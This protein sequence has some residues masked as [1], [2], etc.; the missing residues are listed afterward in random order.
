[1]KNTLMAFSGGFLLC[2]CAVVAHG[3]KERQITIPTY[4]EKAEDYHALPEF[5]RKAYTTGL[6]DGFYGAAMFGPDGKGAEKLGACTKGMDTT[7]ITAIIS[8]YVADHPEG[9]NYPLSMQAYNA[10]NRACPGG[11][12]I[13]PVTQ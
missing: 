7:Q 6:I 10:M 11:L 4:F 5:D 9:W 8:K 2:L 3:Q 12:H 13:E 1:M